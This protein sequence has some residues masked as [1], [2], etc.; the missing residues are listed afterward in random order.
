MLNFLSGS[1][2]V[3]GLVAAAGPIVIHLLNRQRFR[4]VDWAAMDFLREALNRNR[5]ILRLR[6]LTL[7]VL[8]IACVV[9]FGMALA[10]PY[11]FLGNEERPAGV[12][13]IGLAV[14][15]AFGTALWA[16]FAQRRAARAGAAG[17]CF[18][19]AAI[20]ANGIYGFSQAENGGLAD[21]VNS[22]QPVHAVL[23]LDNSLSMAYET[24]GGD[25]LQQ[26]QAQA[27][28]FIDRLPAESRISVIP[29][30]SSE[31]PF[32]LDAYRSKDDARSAVQRIAVVDQAGSAARAIELA[33]QAC[34]RVP[35]LAAKR[36][37]FLGDQQAAAWPTDDSLKSDLMRLPELQIVSVVP[38][39]AANSSPENVWIADF[40]V[41][42]G[43]ADVDTP[44][45]FVAT[46]RCQGPTALTD[47]QV[48]LAIDGLDVESQSIDLE[49]GQSRLVVF[50][51]F[52]DVPVEPG[53]PEFVAAAVRVQTG[54]I[55]GD[56]L[57]N[58]NAR[59]LSVPVVSGLPVVFVDQFGS[60]E[61]VGRNQIGETYAF[62]HLLAPRASRSETNRQPIEIR[63]TTIDQLERRMLED[64]RLVVIAGAESPEGAVPLLREYV[65]QGGPLLIAAGGAFRPD[66]WTE[67]A[68][69]DGQ[70]ILPAPLAAEPF[71]ETPD[72]ALGRLSPFYLDFDSLQHDDFQIE[73]ESRESLQ[74]LYR[75][76]LFFK[77]VQ[78]ESADET[79]ASLADVAAEPIE[80][81]WLSWRSG[82]S[83]PTAG[84]VPRESAPGRPA[85]VLARFAENGLP[86][87]IERRLGDGRVLFF[88][89]GTYSDWNTLAKTN[90]VLLFDR[91]A[92]RLLQGTVPQYNYETAARIT[93]PI[94]SG[95][96]WQYTLKRPSGAEDH[97]TVDALAADAYGVTVRNAGT[98]G[99]YRL[100]A[101]H[102]APG[103]ELD[104]DGF[105]AGGD[106]RV[107][108]LAINGPARESELEW[109]DALA[110]RERLG[111]A[112]FRWIET[113]EPISL[114]GAQIRGRNLWK[115]LVMLVLAGLLL[116]MLLL[117]QP[118]ARNREQVDRR[119]LR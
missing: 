68:W 9:L 99:H 37:A 102:V 44:T 67:H 109:L 66:A 38:G 61:D 55:G 74:D 91:I 111:D 71:G 21:A 33:R 96:R 50:R 51:A 113:Y 107:I 17:L 14:S 46:V 82:N 95:R 42:D 10:R 97:L 5:R 112:P 23:V 92:R 30:C 3:A 69:L 54:T 104:D 72:E 78:V 89:T 8:R 73:G 47:V 98:S 32:S 31:A 15:I 81:P 60:A 16:A 75:L 26:A 119:A 94:E 101:Y 11:L 76:P 115:P 52:V 12:L 58:D 118:H 22:R 36:V 39:S 63:H 6:D 108:P 1:F 117:A 56:R 35:E 87:L 45:T 62:R 86:C 27:V 2:L 57:K 13:W 79:F 84:A 4:T 25:L 88:A 49:P 106:R 85:R 110:L 34:D 40:R 77:A 19:A 18:I 59:F 20:A 100:T 65:L 53:R 7:L 70:G 43:F 103:A 114:E 116:E 28:E 93:L 48:T 41:R 80:F 90:A 83:S 29:L 105:S 24:T 64:A